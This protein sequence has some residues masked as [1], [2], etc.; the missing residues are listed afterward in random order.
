MPKI[1]HQRMF[2]LAARWVDPTVTVT[3]RHT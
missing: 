3:S 2:M 1:T